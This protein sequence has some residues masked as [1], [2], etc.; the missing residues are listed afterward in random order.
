M[1]FAVSLAFSVI[2]GS[3]PALAEP[4]P[5]PAG[6]AWLQ[7][8]ASAARKLNYTGTFVYQYG[9]QVET[10]RIWHYVDA[11][12]EYE[13]LETLDGPVREVIRNNDEVLCY[14][15]D[16]KTVKVEK[17]RPKPFPA[18]VPEHLTALTEYYNI[19]IGERERIAGYEAQSLILEPKDG[20]RYGHKFWADVDTGLLLKAR[21]MNERRE[22]VEQF[23]FT[24]LTIGG[25][26]D[27]EALKSNYNAH[28]P[29]WSLDSANPAEP[30]TV[31]TGWV[32]TSY[33]AGFKKILET[34]R[35]LPGR[36]SPVSHIV[37][38]DGLAAISIFIEPMG[39]ERRSV[40]GISHQGAINIYSRPLAEHMVTVLGEAPSATV[41]QMGKSVA[42]KQ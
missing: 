35:T 28:V 22:T 41:V 2:L 7:K 21:M 42:A 33:P 12:G 16:S 19:R 23:A 34:K 24:Q 31:D 17:R 15:P 36:P 39:P 18:L 10:S 27:K 26:F 4:L 30:A 20:L 32:V 40:H 5:P 6:V 25:V 29:G 14:Y 13:K 8:I 3:A 38:S 9:T 1:K 11:S 37:Y